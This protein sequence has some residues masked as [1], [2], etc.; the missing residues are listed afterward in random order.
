MTRRIAEERPEKE[1]REPFQLCDGDV[2]QKNHYVREC[3]E[4]M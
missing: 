3:V 4:E 2:A 1:V